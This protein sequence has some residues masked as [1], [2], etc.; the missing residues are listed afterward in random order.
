MSS[1]KPVRLDRLLANLGYGGRKD[2][3]ALARQGRITLN[4][5]PL[6][7][8][9]QKL[10]PDAALSD[11]LCID[12]ALVDPLPGFAAMLHKPLGYTCSRKDPG[13]LVFELFPDRWLRRDPAFSPVG[14]LDKETSGLLIFTDDGQL[15]HRISHPRT[16][17]PKTYLAVLDRPLRADAADIF[18][19]GTLM[20][21]GEDKPLLAAE[22]TVLDD[23]TARLTIHEG[24]YHQVRRMFAAIGNHVVAL[25]RETVGGLH[26][27]ADLA[28]GSWKILSTEDLDAI[29]QFR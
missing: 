12:G 10:V 5:A 27:P 29:F 28:P 11:G 22:L 21:D 17:T 13:K 14:R 18:A 23:V 26:L 15:N 20:L 2:I 19:S 24:R 9:D 1:T 3:A 25:H 6:R 8:A 4:G 7:K 16:H